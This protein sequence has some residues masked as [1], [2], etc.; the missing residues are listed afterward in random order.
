MNNS[1]DKNYTNSSCILLIILAIHSK[2]NIH[3]S[4]E[5]DMFRIA[6]GSVC[7]FTLLFAHVVEA[8]E[9][10]Q[11]YRVD[12][13]GSGKLIGTITLSAAKC[14]VL[15]TPDLQDLPPG[16]HG[17]HI[18]QKPLCSD[19]GMAAGDH[20]DPRNTHKHEG[21]YQQ[22]HLGDL[23]VLIVDKQGKATLPVLAPQLTLNDF[24]NH[25]LMIHLHGDN[26]ADTPEKLGGGGER[27]ACGTI[28]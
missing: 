9:L 28:K 19:K 1:L 18:H 11:M 27:I 13:A 14:G 8:N 17:F 16:V 15:L 23:P 12:P 3:F 5:N 6:L 24:K 7:A 4:G 21:P 2:H 10:V 26:Y 25:A 20:L 22:G